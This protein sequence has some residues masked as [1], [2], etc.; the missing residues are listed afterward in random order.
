MNK[1]AIS[2]I[3]TA[4]AG[5]VVMLVTAAI[6]GPDSL[7]RVLALAIAMVVFA[8]VMVLV[9][10]IMKMYPGSKPYSKGVWIGGGIA[11]L[12]G[13]GICTGGK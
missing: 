8:L 6:A 5:T 10:I 7:S 1:S 4:G 3:I 13:L 9:A 2:A 12:I 11:L